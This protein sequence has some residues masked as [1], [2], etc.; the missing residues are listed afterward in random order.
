MWH[1]AAVN[2]RPWSLVAKIVLA[3][4]LV[5]L[6]APPA[7]A[8]ADPQNAYW[9]YDASGELVT[10][11]VADVNHDGVDEFVVVADESNVSLLNAAGVTVWGP[12]RTNEPVLQITAVNTN[13]PTNPELELAIGTRNQL[14]LLNADGQEKWRIELEV[15]PATSGAFDVLGDNEWRRLEASPLAIRPLDANNDGRDELLVALRSGHLRLYDGQTGNQIWEYVG[16]E[17]PAFNALSLIE[18]LDVVGDTVPEIAFTYF[19]DRGF[20]EVSL[21][22]ADGRLLWRHSL[23]GRVTGLQ[24]LGSDA[25]AQTQVA[26]GTDRGMVRLYDGASGAELWR[27]TLNVPITTLTRGM[28]DDGVPVLAVGTAVGRLIAYNQQGVRVIDRQYAAEPNRPILSIDANPI[29]A[30]AESDLRDLP[31]IRFAITLGPA[32]TTRTE[33]ADLLLI[34]S[35]GRA[36]T[37]YTPASTLGLSRLLDINR[38]GLNELLLTA[39]GSLSLRD[40]GLGTDTRDYV[41]DWAYRLDVQPRTAL[42]ADVNQDNRDELLVGADDGRLHLIN[43][44]GNQI[45][46]QNFGGVVTHLAL[47]ERQDG[48]AGSLAPLI[49]AVHNNSV[50]N[51]SGV[52]TVQ[53]W[54]ELLRADG[55]AVWPEPLIL[56]TA[57]SSL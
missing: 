41:V 35:T 12:Y 53:G 13:T 4:L 45:W 34:D 49:V 26:V 36:L 29:T 5:L 23:S 48:T 8:Q 43:D 51:D 37:T 46:E 39:F 56:D 10:V 57:V 40:T 27:R 2:P 15:P 6:S 14:I 32:P 21:L 52:E 28:I 3:C 55:T 7:H 38:D 42:A 11:A 33:P 25:E 47:V 44:M 24:P 1:L 18:T 31:V 54:V 9:S 17:P 22:T 50:V 30:V 19:T 16:P 20:S